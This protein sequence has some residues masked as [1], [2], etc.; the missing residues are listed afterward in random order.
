MA[1][2]QD[3]QTPPQPFLIRDIPYSHSYKNSSCVYL[4]A[5]YLNWKGSHFKIVSVCVITLMSLK[6]TPLGESI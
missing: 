4:F 3:N 5:Q 1:L 2:T 6:A